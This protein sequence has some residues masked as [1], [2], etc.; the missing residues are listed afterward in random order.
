MEGK[1]CFDP[2]F[3]KSSD[4]S[5]NIYK[6]TVDTLQVHNIWLFPLDNGD[7]PAGGP[8]ASTVRHTGNSCQQTIEL[9]VPLRAKPDQFRSMESSA[10]T[11]NHQ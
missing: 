5:V 4:Q 9:T 2:I 8:K 11:I 1:N 7:M 3:L 10:P 6:G